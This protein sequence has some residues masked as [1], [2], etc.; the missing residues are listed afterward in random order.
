[1]NRTW[2]GG[3]AVLVAAIGGGVWWWQAG[4][5]SQVEYRSAA[6]SRGNLQ[7]T[8]A[9]SGAVS[10]VAQVSVGTQVSGQIREVLVDFNSE[11]KAGQLIAQIDPETFEYR[12]RSAQ[13]D[14]DAARAAVLTA[15]ANVVAVQTQVSRAQVDL[16]EAQ[17]D[18]ERKQSL[19]EKQFITQSEAD[20]ARA[21][22]NTSTEAMKAVQAQ[23]GVAQAQVKTAQANVAQREAAL[24]Q[25]RIDLART[26]ITSPVN[27]IVIKRT[28]ERGQTVASSLQSPELFVIA[29]NLSDMQVEAAIDESDV[30][31]LQPGQKASFNVDAFPGQTFEGEIRQVRKAATNVA[32]VVTYVAIVRFA[33][34]Q[35]KLL[36]GMTANVRV[37]TEQRE[38]VL[39]VPNAALRLRIEGV[40]PAAAAASATSA[41][42]ARAQGPRP[43]GGAARGANRSRVYVMGSDGKPLAYAVRV[44]VSDGS[45]T[46]L[47]LPPDS[48]A[49]TALREGVEVLVGTKPQG[50]ATA[51]RSNGPRPPF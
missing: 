39:K 30:G 45:N 7:A 22:V 32:N 36:P 20:K 47:I 13:A 1:M 3:A 35:G 31:R 16:N 29:Q 2:I 18:F 43:E 23:V 21:L 50:S 24:A 46:E 51:P 40:E 11:V 48:P 4:A 10:P 19:V 25:A 6:I 14:V 41:P 5:G 27:G 26:R 38:N 33:N 42:G 28:I 9:A 17:R 12:V 8:V 37:V 34:V 49:A 44:G 15:Q